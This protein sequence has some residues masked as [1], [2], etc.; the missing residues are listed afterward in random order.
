M[1]CSTCCCEVDE[2]TFSVCPFCGSILTPSILFEED[3]TP[4]KNDEEI[5]CI[6]EDEQESISKEKNSSLEGIIE[7]P[8]TPSENATLDINSRFLKSIPINQLGLLPKTVNAITELGYYTAFDLFYEKIN[9]AMLP[10]GIMADIAKIKDEISYQL[11]LINICKIQY[12]S[13]F[14]K[15]NPI[16]L[17]DKVYDYLKSAAI[18]NIGDFYLLIQN[19]C[20]EEIIQIFGC[21][22][23]SKIIANIDR[24]SDYCVA[25]SILTK[26]IEKM[27]FK[28][29]HENACSVPIE[30]FK[31]LGLPSK[32]VT[33]FNQNGYSHLA[34]LRRFST[35]HLSGLLYNIDEDGIIILINLVNTFKNPEINK[36][37]V[38]AIDKMPQEWK[39]IAILRDAGETLDAIGKKLGL[40]RERIRQIESK[41]VSKLEWCREY[42]SSI[43]FQNSNYIRVTE[44]E[45]MI[46]KN[47]YTLLL[48]FSFKMDEKY[49]YIPYAKVILHSDPKDRKKTDKYITNLISNEIGD[50]LVNLFDKCDELGEI[51]R[52]NNLEYMGFDELI[53]FLEFNN[54]KI[55]G[56]YISK[57]VFTKE[58]IIEIILE[59]FFPHGIKIS[60]SEE[61][62]ADIEKLKQIIRDK[63]GVDMQNL[64]NHSISSIISRAGTILAGKGLYISKK[65]ISLDFSILDEIYEFMRTNIVSSMDYSQ[66]FDTF[67]GRLTMLTP[68]NNYEYLHGVLKEFYPEGF[69]YRKTCIVRKGSEKH[70]KNL[71]MKDCVYSLLD[72]QIEPI[73]VDQ[74]QEEIGSY[75][76][77]SLVQFM[78][79]AQDISHCGNQ[80][81]IMSSYFR[82]TE[83]E[84][85][86]LISWIEMKLSDNGGYYSMGLFLEYLQ[87][88][89]PEFLSIHPILNQNY[90]ENYF[91]M[92][93]VP[94]TF[95]YA[96]PHIVKKGLIARDISTKS[97]I[98]LI[99]KGKKIT[100]RSIAN[101]TNK[102]KLSPITVEAGFSDYLN[103]EY[104]QISQSEFIPEQ[105]FNNL[106][107]K[108][109]DICSYVDS[110]MKNNCFTLLI[111]H[112]YS[113]LP[114]IGYEWNNYLIRSIIV[115]YLPEKYR[116][117]K[118]KEYKRNNNA[119]IFVKADSSSKDYASFV[120]NDILIKNGLIRMDIYDLLVFLQLRG[121]AGEHLSDS[122]LE[123]NMIKLNEKDGTIIVNSSYL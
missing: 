78:S 92:C 55:Q 3:D 66:L 50:E 54:Y 71:H 14:G 1:I 76:K 106:Q 86:Q 26:L 91:K 58:K 4:I 36:I 90:L 57:F 7:E 45:D 72:K 83:A 88:T 105:C 60:Q 77:S 37:I 5:E 115:K 82:L 31:A 97:V 101:F 64:S 9:Q 63:F 42:I 110:H 6:T 11:E 43:L 33:F 25:H 67:K 34:S 69:S 10:I 44:I 122:I 59:D 19:H 20:L 23:L 99:F 30:A 87:N 49:E 48:V 100:S 81:Y 85:T 40:S 123:S 21:N 117:L 112:D 18:N 79:Y 116:E 2:K 52:N 107:D 39:D 15:Y 111:N 27:E 84:Q 12:N 65:N 96:R 22:K 13:D 16:R 61:Y 70:E 93:N 113:S 108:L 53:C 94:I 118:L 75:S 41:F 32:T 62:S 35:G 120:V 114:Y 80:L 29:I 95:D 68:I 38:R 51:F 74:I 47:Q 103:E 8:S 56:D 98:R 109:T 73:S 46:G 24:Y 89:H 28:Q 102:Y 104:L 121:L 119:S 17:T